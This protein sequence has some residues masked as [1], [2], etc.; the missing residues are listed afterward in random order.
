MGG[1][2]STHRHVA[3]CVP[4]CYVKGKLGSIVLAGD[5][6]KFAWEKVVGQELKVGL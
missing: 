1:K 3:S 5:L 4:P 2:S 6:R